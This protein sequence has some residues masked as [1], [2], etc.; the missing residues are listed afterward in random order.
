MTTGLV[1]TVL[2]T[3]NVDWVWVIT[4]ISWNSCM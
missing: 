4:G 1:H 3:N 2:F